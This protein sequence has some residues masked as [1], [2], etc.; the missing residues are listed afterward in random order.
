MLPNCSTLTVWRLSTLVALIV[1]SFLLPIYFA[2]A[3]GFIVGIILMKFPIGAKL[4][5]LPSS[6]GPV[7]PKLSDCVLTILIPIVAIIYVTLVSWMGVFDS[8][9][10]MAAMKFTLNVAPVFDFGMSAKEHL[11]IPNSEL[12]IYSLIIIHAFYTFWLMVFFC[13]LAFVALGSKNLILHVKFK[14]E[15]AKIIRANRS[16]YYYLLLF[17]LGSSLIFYY[18]KIYIEYFEVKNLSIEPNKLIFIF[19]HSVNNGFS[20]LILLL[21]ITTNFVILLKFCH[22]LAASSNPDLSKEK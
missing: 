19:R 21:C 3:V 12:N 15:P 6:V 11:N 5:V 22:F 2:V 14:S 8:Q 1:S 13:F 16:K 20:Y 17:V 10:A 9:L 4:D 18:M 7:T